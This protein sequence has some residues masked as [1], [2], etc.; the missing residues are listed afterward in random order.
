MVAA[1]AE[2]D[3]AEVKVEADGEEAELGAEATATA[4]TAVARM[5][6]AEVAEKV[7]G[8]SV[9]ELMGVEETAG[10]ARAV[11]LVEKTVVTGLGRRG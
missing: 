6:A 8:M 3:R 11:G 10:A 2:V 7:A 4:K 1:M 5:E 9:A